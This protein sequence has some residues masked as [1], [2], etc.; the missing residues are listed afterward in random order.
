VVIVAVVDMVPSF[1]A[2]GVNINTMYK[3]E[4]RPRSVPDP[5][6]HF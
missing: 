4:L 6:S 3:A 1:G 5:C 2:V